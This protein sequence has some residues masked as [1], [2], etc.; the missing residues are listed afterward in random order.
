MMYT[1]QSYRSVENT[2]RCGARA[3][4][5]VLALVAGVVHA[6]VP[7]TSGHA[8]HWYASERSGEGW[9]LELRDADSAWL[10]WFTYDEDG[11]Q[12]WM[13]ATGQVTTD[14]EGGQRIEFPQLVVTRGAR[15]GSDFDP[16]DVIRELAGSARMEFSGCDAGQFSYEAFGQSQ[17]FNVQRLAR[18][19]GSR[20][21]TPHGV[22]GRDVADYAG[23][24]GSWYDPSHNGEGYA[25]HWS[26]PDEAI[27]TW[28][29]YDDDGNQYWML[30]TGRRDAEGR[31]Q[32][33]DMHA[34]RGARFGAAFDP[35]D[36]ERFAWGELRVD[37]SCD[38]GGAHYE[39]VLP[40][41]GAGAFELTRLTSLYEVA[42]PWQPPALS[43]LYSVEQFDVPRLDDPAAPDFRM[44][45][46]AQGGQLFGVEYRTRQL[47]SWSPGDAT[48]TP[49]PE[50]LPEGVDVDLHLSDDGSI[51][52]V[53][54]A[55]DTVNLPAVWSAG[56]G[57]NLL[58]PPPA[59]LSS[60]F[61]W[62]VSGDGT[63][64][65]GSRRF[66][67]FAFLSWIWSADEGY[68][69][70][71]P[72]TASDAVYPVQGNWLARFV[73]DDGRVVVGDGSVPGM[74]MGSLQPAH[75]VR[76]DRSGEPQLLRDSE[77]RLLDLPGAVSNDGRVVFG[78][79]R[80]RGNPLHPFYGNPWYWIEGGKHAWLGRVLDGDEEA[81]WAYCEPQDVS[82]DGNLMVGLC[83]VNDGTDRA[84]PFVWTAHTGMVSL[85][86][87]DDP[88]GLARYRLAR[89]TADGRHVLLVNALGDVSDALTWRS[90]VLRLT[91]I[92]PASSP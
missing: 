71:E 10:Y 91:P 28:Y 29:S 76:W 61:A 37:L 25:I 19:M 26:T 81:P 3:L 57:W 8:G 63:W 14:G 86:V 82:A 11:G 87:A 18:V 80:E 59:E 92:A 90:R 1:T 72:L 70:A 45:A 36:V 15:F 30:G 50:P 64:L 83:R 67:R 51:R 46:M 56:A 33:D 27:V 38:A 66:A 12:R 77:G 5:F 48:L 23:Q 65:V 6:G 24:S 84:R 88:E 62:G 35:A 52:V 73:S 32:F 69:A 7:I 20:C 41:F 55:E 89:I 79:G 21:E 13:T 85:P 16:A 68:I 49:A 4:A 31:I 39:S 40:S 60:P 22:T 54:T 53:N 58:D 2:M 75:T 43:A 44:D 9:V 78:A 17:T 47:Y 74:F 42:C 34:T